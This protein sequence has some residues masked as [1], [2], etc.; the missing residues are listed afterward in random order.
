MKKEFE[1]E[2][3]IDPRLMNIEVLAQHLREWINRTPNNPD[4]QLDGNIRQKR[5]EQW[6]VFGVRG[7][8]DSKF[9]KPLF[10]LAGDTKKVA[11]EKFLELFD[12]SNGDVN[13]IFVTVYSSKSPRMKLALKEGVEGWQCLETV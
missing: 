13:K 8:N 6:L 2:K 3:K 4:L 10:Q 9:N 5:I 11:V 1:I 7:L 12:K